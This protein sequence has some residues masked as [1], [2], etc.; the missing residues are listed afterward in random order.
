MIL[1]LLASGPV[2]GYQLQ[3]HLVQSRVHAW[4]DVRPG[5]IYQ[6]LKQLEAEGL[7]EVEAEEQTGHRI[8]A[9][10][11]ITARG[12]ME[13]DELLAKALREAPRGFPSRFYT[14]LAFLHLVSPEQALAAVN[15]LVP[16]LEDALRSWSMGESLKAKYL[17]GN[18]AAQAVFVNGRAHIEADL[19][20]LK[21]LARE[22][23][24]KVG[25]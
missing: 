19:V 25:E 11:R 4:A 1:G 12:R 13:L 20:L 5:S 17:Q 21:T 18:E 6:C 22:L 23:E 10:Y 15:G 9:V 24:L 16:Q 7:A 8:R 3:K 14:A 2:H